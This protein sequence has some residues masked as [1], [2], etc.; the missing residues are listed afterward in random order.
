M[1]ATAASL[2][3]I[4][5]LVGGACDSSTRT[6]AT[7]T[8]NA[9]T[10]STTIPSIE[11]TDFRSCLHGEFWGFTADDSIAVV[12]FVDV[13]QAVTIQL[14]DPSG[15]VTVEIR[16]GT[17]LSEEPVCQGTGISSTDRYQLDS[18]HQAEGHT[19]VVTIGDDQCPT[20]GGV[21]L[22]H[23]TD[24]DGTPFVSPLTLPSTTMLG[25]A[26]D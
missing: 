26:P 11:L 21:V 3:V 6:A 9:P 5:L 20:N 22:Q 24:T 23:L 16:H 8:S 15:R 12:A 2:M 19:G 25:C 7:T 14:P 1:R 4:G 17:H 10:T 18:T 13:A